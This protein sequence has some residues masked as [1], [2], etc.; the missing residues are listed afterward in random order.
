MNNVY[1]IICLLLL[2]LYAASG[3]FAQDG[4]PFKL[5]VKDKESGKSL[6]GATVRSSSG[7]QVSSDGNG[8][9][10]VIL[11]PQD[12]AVYVRLLGYEPDTI[13]LP[14]TGN[15]YTVRLVSK[16]NA[17]EEVQINT[18]YQR[19]SK[20]R[21]TG[22]VNKVDEA[23][24]KT[25]VSTSIIDRL[26]NNVPGLVFNKTGGNPSNQTQISI[27]GQ[28]TLF[29][30]PDPLIV[31]D[32]FPYD[33]DLS[34]INPD[35]IESIS[36]LKDAG[37]ASVWGA[38]AANGVIVLTSKKGSA[39]SGL[40]IDLTAQA[41][42]G[43]RPNLKYE[44]RISSADYI[45]IERELF[46]KGLYKTQETSANK[47]VLTPVVELLIANRDGLLAKEDLDAQLQSLGQ[48]DLDSEMS[49]YYM[50]QSLNQHYALS[51]NKATAGGNW[52]LSL[53]VDKNRDNLVKNG[54]E[55]LNGRLFIEQKFWKD[56]LTFSAN[57]ARNN[58]N[59][60]TPNPGTLYMT[61][62][63]QLYPYA[64]LKDD[65][66]N[67]AAVS[68]DYRSTY[69]NSVMEQNI[70]LLD[71][72]Y[73]PLD[74]VD[75]WDKKRQDREYRIDFNLG[76]K[77]IDGLLLNTSYQYVDRSLEDRDNQS[78][79]SYGVRSLINQFTTVLDEG[80]ILRNIPLG[81]ILDVERQT[82]ATH[83][84]RLQATIDKTM[85]KIFNI[86][87]V[88]GAEVNRTA[89]AGLQ[90]RFYGYNAERAGISSVDYLTLFP[91]FVNPAGTN[92]IPFKNDVSKLTDRFVSYYQNSSISIAS[93]YVLTAS[94]R[95]DQSNIFGVRTNQKGVPL[96]SVGLA[97]SINKE[98]FFKADLFSQL[99]LRT[100]YGLSGNVNRNLSAFTTA[101]YMGLAPFSR[102]PYATIQNP[103]NAELRWERTK[104]FNAGV[105]FGFL[106]N[107]I[108]GS[109]DYFQKRGVDLIGDAPYPASSG[110]T[111]YRGNVAAS[112]GHGY[113]LLLNGL[114]VDQAFRWNSTVMLS[115]AKDI[116]SDYMDLTISGLNMIQGTSINPRVGK[117]LYS[118]YSFDTEGLDP[119]TGDP[120]GILNGEQ[121]TD[122]NAVISKT[123]IEDLLYY[124]SSRPTTNA[125]FRNTFNWRNW[126][127][128]TNISYRANYFY[129]LNSIRYTYNNVLDNGLESR[130]ADYLRRW[131]NPGDEQHTTIPS[132][133]TTANANRD[134]LYLNGESLIRRADHIRWEDLAISYRMAVAKDWLKSVEFSFYVNNLG[135]IWR[136]SKEKIDPD[137]A[138][139]GQRPLP[140]AYSFGVRLGF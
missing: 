107:R 108:N 65:Q 80:K 110:V 136:K 127:L 29:S 25:V 53:G 46:D 125:S 51:I 134:N 36:I 28:S 126:N 34:S 56:R 41:T 114:I 14:V 97:W 119:V 11:R 73:R 43:D 63:K 24:L 78:L 111:R 69:L 99:K 74:E 54:F 117:P 48:I 137:F 37:A 39:A 124:G 10:T 9:A 66:G 1:K 40:K 130:H 122:W 131:I 103:P 20:E 7:W 121:S 112:K 67:N 55:R 123:K 128:T 84:F 22:A 129:R 79:N 2:N 47:T 42:I 87:S 16:I 21:L 60:F 75:L 62:L 8:E 98:N 30:R 91:S 58:T 35:D 101:S 4:K 26:A 116:V 89:T 138:G 83:R 76:V 139:I 109:F 86:Q 13:L 15:N 90:N 71:W 68:K 18:G 96:W 95:F 93:R 88:V 64:R 23:I 12:K 118:M 19:L 52:L 59:L 104:V 92:Q 5:I 27:R 50:Q 102:L 3:L 72:Y 105:D 106:N 45:Q 44:P 100:T 132:V 32:N 6:Q 140:R 120:V 38:R 115:L 85:A 17:I 94:T 49:K 133:P 33:G 57:I 82:M 61:N 31:L 70:G 81:N 77:L 113:E 135:L